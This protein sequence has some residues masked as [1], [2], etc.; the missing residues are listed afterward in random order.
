MTK[1]HDAK[2][3]K[4]FL[5]K[6]SLPECVEMKM[7]EAYEAIYAQARKETVTETSRSAGQA[8]Q[9]NAGRTKAFPK[10]F[11]GTLK[12][13]GFLAI[14][15]VAL[16][17]SAMAVGAILDRY[18]RMKAMS[19]EEKTTVFEDMQKSGTV[20][21]LFNREFTEEELSRY[22]DLENAYQAD[23]RFPERSIRR[24][25]A[26]EEYAGVGVCIM[27]TEQGEENYM[28][29]P[30]RELTDEELLEIIEY[31]QKVEYV[32][33]EKGQKEK[34]GEKLWEERLS[35]LTDEEVDRYYLAYSGASFSELVGG[36]CR[37]GRSTRKGDKVLSQTEERRYQ[38]MAKAY[39]E[40]NRIPAGEL[41]IMDDPNE[42]DGMS[43][44]YC[45]W[46]SLFYLPVG[47]LTEEDFLEI[48][49]FET[50]GK[51]CME[52]ITEEV[53]LGKRS[54]FPKEEVVVQV[55]EELILEEKAF[56]TKQGTKKEL[57]NAGIGDIVTYGSYEQ[58]GDLA[59]GGEPIEWY[60]LDETEDARMLLSVMVLDGHKYSE[61]QKLV[62]WKDSDLRAWLNDVFIEEA[63]TEK[64]R[65]EIL[66][67]K[68]ANN[69]G[70]DCADRV[71]LLSTKECMEYFGISLDEKGADPYHFDEGIYQVGLTKK[72]KGEI[73]KAFLDVADPRRF[74]KA[75]QAKL[76]DGVHMNAVLWTI[77]EGRIEN[78]MVDTGVDIS[79]MFGYCEW[80]VRDID[81]SNPAGTA[82]KVCTETYWMTSYVDSGCG[83]RPVI[84]VKK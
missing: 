16:G 38:D 22:Q 64:E 58:D 48:I 15:M 28:Y 12:V 44:A 37:D 41:Q 39:R 61:E 63:F 46:E 67:K 11:A 6:D 51:Y 76:W 62:G 26:G 30:D 49:D 84:W 79:D 75:T 59:N 5:T 72:E 19:E 2:A 70:G 66:L 27:I 65:G 55:P 56:A 4:A 14:C 77:G 8:T 1:E 10:R 82:R 71:T 69:Y 36:F 45:R 50:K 25:E 23:E 42:Y 81:L 9:A 35:V 53:R 80:W 83:V 74:G 60:V 73:L 24:L 57:A 13:A 29:F 21:F 43:V 52:R 47:E 54:D 33:K 20:D 3:K 7:Q 68:V 18:Q 31:R 32:W 34:F 17:A 40:S 78:M